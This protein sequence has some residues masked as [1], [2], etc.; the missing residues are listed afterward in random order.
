MYENDRRKY[1]KLI[2]MD[3]TVMYECSGHKKLLNQLSQI[4]VFDVLRSTLNISRYKA[5]EFNFNR[6][7]IYIHE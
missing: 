1:I 4:I 6:K 7:F 3:V 5:I 2:H